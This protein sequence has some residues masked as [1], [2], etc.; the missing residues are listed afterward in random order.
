MSDYTREFRKLAKDK[1][2]QA[3]SEDKSGK[4]R[5]G[6]RAAKVFPTLSNVDMIEYERWLAECRARLA[7]IQGY[8]G[9]G[10][11]D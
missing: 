11:T 6:R 4:K 10:W 1:E 7:C 8:G 3:E 5:S 2:E 9:D